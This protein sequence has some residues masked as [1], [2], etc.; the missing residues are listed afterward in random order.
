MK[1]KKLAALFLCLMMLTALIPGFQHSASAASAV[2][3]NLDWGSMKYNVG[4]YITLTWNVTGGNNVHV[5]D[6]EWYYVTEE[7]TIKSVYE[8]SISGKN[9]SHTHRV[10]EGG[11]LSFLFYFNYVNDYGQVEYD[12]WYNTYYIDA[13]G[14]SNED[15]GWTYYTGG[16]RSKGWIRDSGNWYLMNSNGVMQTGWA[17]NSG[18][19]YLLNSSGAMQTGWTKDGGNWYFLGSNGAMRTGWVSDSGSWYFMNPS[20]SMHTGWLLQ[21]GTWY[22]LWGNGAMATGT[23][24]VDGRNNKFSSSGAWLGYK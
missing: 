3:P 7:D 1:T 24:Y 12:S 5:T 9:G 14:W 16:S 13:N 4:E 10:Q 8:Y 2:D 21:G 22:Y 11:Q 19:W 20:G 18:S 15:I 6:L 23:Q 17:K